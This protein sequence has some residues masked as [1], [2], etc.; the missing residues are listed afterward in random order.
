MINH[1]KKRLN[2]FY[3][4]KTWY[5]DRESGEI[6]FYYFHKLLC[7]FDETKTVSGNW[8]NYVSF[9]KYLAELEAE[10]SSSPLQPVH[11]ERRTDSAL[12]GQESRDAL[13]QY[14]GGSVQVE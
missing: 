4:P 7:L 6:I 2:K 12:N 11:R 5:V 8:V 1:L 14:A 10:A 9:F 3:D 13:Q